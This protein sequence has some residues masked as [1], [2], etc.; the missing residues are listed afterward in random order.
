MKIIP[1]ASLLALLFA[2]AGPLLAQAPGVEQGVP[3]L[4]GSIPLEVSLMSKPTVVDW[5][6]DGNKDLVVGQYTDGNVWLFI[7]KGTDAEPVFNG[8][9]L[10]ESNGTPIT[11]TFG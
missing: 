6:N 9:S 4:D 10:I 2:A 11:T 8:G 3:V 7:N 1:I 5:N